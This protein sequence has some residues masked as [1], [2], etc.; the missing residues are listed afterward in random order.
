MKPPERI[1]A[2]DWSGCAATSS[3]KKHIRAAIIDATDVTILEEKTRDEW[4]S[5][6]IEEIK[7]DT[8]PT[9]VGFDFAFSFPVSFFRRRN[10]G[11]INQLWKIAEEEGENWMKSCAPPFWGRPGKKRPETHMTDGFRRTDKDISV[12]HISPKSP[13]QIGGA[14]AVGTG[15]IRGMPILKRLHESGFSI[16]PFDEPASPMVVEIYPR[17]L[18]REVNKRSRESRCAYLLSDF[19]D[20]P[21][22]VRQQ[23][24]ESEDAFDAIVSARK[25]WEHRRNF[26]ELQQSTDCVERLEGCIWA[27]PTILNLPVLATRLPIH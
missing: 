14:G 12:G 23:A 15:S 10:I 11:V 26:A 17:L 16:W 20:L 1:I 21:G 27:P 19:S 6:L 8:R 22:G 5:W 4:F 13:F 3:Q 18:T 7:R 2:I 25:M 9:V 24:E